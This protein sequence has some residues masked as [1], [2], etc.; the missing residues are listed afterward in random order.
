VFAGH[1]HP[2]AA[3]RKPSPTPDGAQRADDRRLPTFGPD[4]AAVSLTALRNL[5]RDPFLAELLPR[6]VPVVAGAS[7]FAVRCRGRTSHR[8][9]HDMVHLQQ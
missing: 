5:A 7:E 6:L 8:E 9:R 1:G 4:A 3:G 2:R